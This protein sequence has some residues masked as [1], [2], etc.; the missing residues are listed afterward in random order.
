MKTKLKVKGLIERKLENPKYR[1]EF[2][3]GYEA[4]KLEVQLLN[5]LERN[6]LTYNDLAKVLHTGKS[7]ISRD[8]RGG[9]IYSATVSR[10]SRM[11]RALGLEF[12]PM[13][14]PIKKAARILPQIEKLIAA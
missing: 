6:H 9:G 5:A 4:F 3:E 11:A 8:L 7:N 2:A 13:L 12:V 1:R 10:V 14:I